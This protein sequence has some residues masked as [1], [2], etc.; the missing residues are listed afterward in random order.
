MNTQK[1]VPALLGAL[2]LVAFGLWALGASYYGLSM[3]MAGLCF[4]LFAL[5]ALS[6]V[7][8]FSEFAGAGQPCPDAAL[9]PRSLRRS[10][11][12]P[13]LQIALAVLALRLFLYI[14]AYLVD[15]RVNGY[16]GGILDGLSRL[17]LRTDSPS[18][19][20]I[21]QNWYVTQGDP[22][23]HIVFFPL[24]PVFIR[25]FSWLTGGNL[26]AAALLVSNL[27]AMGSGILLYELAALDL[28]RRDSLFAT[29][30]ALLLP[31]AIFLGAPMTESLFLFLSLACAYCSR[32]QNYLLAGLFG[33]L[34]AFT[35]S[36][37][38]LLAV[39]MAAEML[40]ALLRDGKW[41]ARRVWGYI[42][43]LFLV[44]LGTAGYLAVNYF[45]TGSAF[46]F[47][48]YQREHWNQSLGLF[49]NTVA[50]QTDYLMGALGSGDLRMAL[51]LFLPNLVCILG[52]LAVM[53]ASARKLRPSYLLY[54]LV[55]FAVS[56]G[57]SWL[58]SAPRYLAV[59]FP[60]AFG[61]IALLEK[62]PRYLRALAGA[63]LFLSLCAYAILYILGYPVY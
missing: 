33:G 6:L 62:A 47:L 40:L 31:G 60:L 43:C 48:T 22:R 52:S 44:A 24:Y 49:F 7:P 17:W 42:G 27:C 28:N 20:G 3:L 4:A 5:C 38:A 35:R 37:G 57:C 53:A 63:L 9:G 2:L 8:A 16:G 61:L 15:M 34:A 45:V 1:V 30:L 50:Y 46:T 32:K 29:A 51:G 11:R 10:R 56:I 54:F 13:F 14:L 36:V 26:F 55:Y 41:S 58:L 21:A 19:L 39:F 23:F 25:A 12:H 59:C 18:Y